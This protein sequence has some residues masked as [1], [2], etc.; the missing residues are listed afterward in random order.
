MKYLRNLILA[1]VIVANLALIGGAGAQDLTSSAQVVH[2][3]QR[4]ENLF[5][6]ALRYGV[7]VAQVKLWNNITNANLIYAGQSLYIYNGQTNPPP[8]GKVY[9]VKAGD[10]LGR[11]ARTYGVD[12]WVLARVNNIV[13]LNY[14]YVGQSLTIPDFTTQ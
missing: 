10:T 2:I 9:V 12:M 13:N 3:V 4:G 5:R 8:T 1:V 14:I 11:I 6:I 7:S